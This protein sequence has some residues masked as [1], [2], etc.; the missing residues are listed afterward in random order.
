M[1]RLDS[2]KNR[3]SV[4]NAINIVKDISFEN[5]KEV[6]FARAAVKSKTI[7]RH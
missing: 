3:M 1:G 5:S 4:C 6:T 7:K 2:L